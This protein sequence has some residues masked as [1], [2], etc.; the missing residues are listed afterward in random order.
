MSRIYVASSWRNQYQ[1]NVVERLRIAGHHVYD[2]RHPPHRDGGFAWHQLDSAWQSWDA[3]KYREVLLTHPIASHGFVADLRG[4]QWADT[5]V[6]VLPA[7][8]SAHL[9]AG[10]FC[11][12]GKNCIV[13]LDGG[14]PDLM[15]LLASTICVS[16]DEVLLALNGKGE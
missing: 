7:G 8:R 16:I 5:C 3:E 13:L 2:F 9:E 1:P 15:N 11:G 12:A 10:W 14:E 4:M 6:L